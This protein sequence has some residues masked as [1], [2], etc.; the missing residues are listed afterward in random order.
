[1]LIASDSTLCENVLVEYQSIILGH[2]CDYPVKN[3]D[4]SKRCDCKFATVKNVLI[5]ASA[6][7]FIVV[8]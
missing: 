4:Y 2:D 8:Y 1:M 7:S 3:N 5:F 6:Q